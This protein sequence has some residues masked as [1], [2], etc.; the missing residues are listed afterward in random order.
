VAIN[1]VADN[2][3]GVKRRS[4]HGRLEVNLGCTGSAFVHG[5]CCFG[6]LFMAGMKE[7]WCQLRLHNAEGGLTDQ[8]VIRQRRKRSKLD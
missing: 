5:I 4:P 7:S 8:R 3:G 1:R 6:A 2:V